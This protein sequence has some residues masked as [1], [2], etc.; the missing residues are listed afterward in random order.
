MSSREYEVMLWWMMPPPTTTTTTTHLLLL[1]TVERDPKKRRVKPVETQA[2]ILDFD[3]EESSDD[4]DF[5]IEDHPDV[6]DDDEDSMD[7]HG[8]G[9]GSS[10]GE[11]EEESDASDFDE[12]DFN[13][14]LNIGK[15]NGLSIAEVLEKA[16]SQQSDASL[17]VCF[18]FQ[19]AL[20]L[21]I[22]DQEQESKRTL[23]TNQR[24]R[25]KRLRKLHES[26][27]LLVSCEIENQNFA[28]KNQK[29]F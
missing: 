2:S 19:S 23:K 6:S 27:L 14:G 7:S 24:C 21:K 20:N 18:R 5:R 16:K 13:R 3:L 11:E 1:L 26:I 8:E 17:K 15:S 25:Y 4:S 29:L 12:D 10:D 9:G 28:H 22:V